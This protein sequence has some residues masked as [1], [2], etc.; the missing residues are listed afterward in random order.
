M[1]DRLNQ[2]ENLRDRLSGNPEIDASD[3]E[4]LEAFIDRLDLLSSEYSTSRKAKLLNHMVI[5]A[6]QHGAIA[7]LVDDRDVV[8]DVIASRFAFSAV[9]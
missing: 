2:L 7:D 4:A 9:T 5:I 1:T 8:E 6:E 3:A